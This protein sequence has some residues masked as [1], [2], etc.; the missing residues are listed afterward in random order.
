MREGDF[1]GLGGEGKVVEI[2]ETF[3][4]GLEKNKH[5]SKRQHLGTGGAGKEA[6][7]ALVER[8]GRVQSHHVAAV[9]AKTPQPLL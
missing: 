2:D 1:V 8:G 6:V 9:T 5:A 7:F 4:G 3:V